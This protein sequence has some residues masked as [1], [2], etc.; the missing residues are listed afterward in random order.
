MI[1]EELKVAKERKFKPSKNQMNKIH[2][3]RAKFSICL[4]S[5]G[6]GDYHIKKTG[7]GR[8][9]LHTSHVARHTGAYPGFSNMKRL[10]VF[11]PPLPSFPN[12]VEC[13]SIAGLP[14][15]QYKFTGTHLYTWAERDNVKV[16]C[17]A[18][19][20]NIRSQGSNPDRSPQGRAH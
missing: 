5:L 14:P 1:N 4:S 15:R 3:F 12:W 20:H 13:Q 19:Q 2:V 8:L 16:K 7:I 10:G 9:S 11:L 18:Q 6:G 17:L